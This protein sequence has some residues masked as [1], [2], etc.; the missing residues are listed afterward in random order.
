VIVTWKSLA[1]APAVALCLALLSGCSPTRIQTTSATP[2][3]T[4]PPDPA[5][6]AITTSPPE[7]ASSPTPTA[8][9]TE[10]VARD[11]EV[12]LQRSNE[13]VS[14]SCRANGEIDLQADSVTLRAVG[15]CAAISVDGQNN[16]VTAEYADELSVDGSNNSVRAARAGEAD[17]DGSHNAVVVRGISRTLDVQGTQNRVRFG[18]SPRTDIEDGNAVSPLPR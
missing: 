1:A 6:P 18:G 5:P 8:D 13:V 4:A 10:L 16:V 12:E 3:G 14:I 2:S 11:G 9:R 17:V 15:P 7:P